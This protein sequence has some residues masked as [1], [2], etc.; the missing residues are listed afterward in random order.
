MQIRNLLYNRNSPGH[1]LNM[2]HNFF[3]LAA[4]ALC[5]P[6]VKLVLLSIP[7][8]NPIQSEL[9]KLELNTSRC[10]IKEKPHHSTSSLSHQLCKR[11]HLHDEHVADS[12]LRFTLYEKLFFLNHGWPIPHNALHIFSPVPL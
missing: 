12:V 10:P 6:C 3:F 4:K 2:I 11:Q 1:F 8:P 5:A 7:K 9:A